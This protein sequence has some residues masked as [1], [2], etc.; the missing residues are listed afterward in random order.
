MKM[1]EI[2]C[3]YKITIEKSE[4]NIHLQIYTLHVDIFTNHFKLKV[5]HTSSQIQKKNVTNI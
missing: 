4:E 2:V 5:V 1:I 3:C